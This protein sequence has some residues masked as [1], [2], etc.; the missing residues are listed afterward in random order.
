MS[1]AMGDL[2]VGLVL[3]GGGAVMWFRR[4]NGGC[5]ALLALTGAA[6]LAGGFSDALLFVHRGPLVHLVL[7]YP[8]GRVRSR[9]ARIVVAAA[10]VDGF[11]PHVAREP[12]LTVALIVAFLLAV[13]AEYRTARGVERHARATAAVLALAIGGALAFAAIVRAT[14]AGADAPAVW[15]YDVAVVVTAVGLTADLVW[16]R[17]TGAAVTGLLVDLGDRREPEALRAALARALG[18][19]GLR[20]AYHINEAEDWVDE[21]GRRIDLQD[22][23][24]DGRD[25]T[26]VM[27]ADVAV[28]ALVHDRAALADG[29]LKAS[30]AAAVRLAVASAAMQVEI[31]SRVRDVDAS[32]R[33]LVEAG[34]AERRQLGDE[35]RGGVERR[36]DDVTRQLEALAGDHDGD[37][38]LAL[39]RLSSELGD[40]HRD[41]QRFAQGI[42]PRTLVE[43]G[44]GPALAEL[45]AQAA[46]P[47]S[48]AVSP[49]R[50]P[51][52][53]EAAVFFVCSEGLSNVAK[54]AA[55]DRV[56]IAVSRTEAR[57]VVRVDDDGGGGA[58]LGRGSGL[59]GLADRVQALGGTLRVD[60]PPGGGTRLQAELPLPVDECAVS[61]TIAS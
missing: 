59:R 23:G 20:V 25:I 29:D 1:E 8:S 11:F 24:D 13:G 35:L 45:A 41:L 38:G 15:A 47:V 6:W 42:H 39:R 34:D 32:R 18:D 30:V 50:F 48:L 21:I 19:P 51:A 33:R 2:I 3:C 55:A 22:A 17:W 56:S 7:A 27:D 49:D 37:A 44:L 54:H 36:L 4:A 31:V 28:A 61:E 16:G 9:A 46:V 14:G 40:A 57:L 26:H 58:D 43:R 10:Y 53:H 60:A 5:A 12:W 52:S